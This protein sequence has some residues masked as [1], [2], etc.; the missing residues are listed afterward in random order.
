MRS[1]LIRSRPALAA[2]VALMLV[3]ASAGSAAAE[4]TA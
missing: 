2:L 1:Y 3:L 4:E